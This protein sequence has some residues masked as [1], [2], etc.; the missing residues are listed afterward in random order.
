MR[1][2]VLLLLAIFLAAGVVFG[3]AVL[4]SPYLKQIEENKAPQAQAPVAEPE[5]V[6]P[7][8]RVVVLTVA[9]QPGDFI[10]AA[11]DLTIASIPA[12]EAP[13]DAF[14]S[15][16]VLSDAIA[17]NRLD[18]WEVLLAGKPG[19]PVTQSMLREVEKD[20]E[21]D[22]PE[23]QP[24][25]VDVAFLES[26]ATDPTIV[27][28]T[29][30]QLTAVRLRSDAIV[31]ISVESPL[32][33]IGDGSWVGR[34]TIVS[35][36]TLRVTSL[37]VTGH[38]AKPVFYAKLSPKEAERVRAGQAIANGRLRVEPHRDQRAIPP[39]GHVCVAQTCFEALPPDHLMQ[40]FLGART[41]SGQDTTATP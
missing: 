10:S 17:R 40:D 33:S 36:A 31:D 37:D 3:G 29:E 1:R 23:V 22:E 24:N 7:D 41:G 5:P 11:T 8:R 28:F 32:V 6:E 34:E 27:L 25:A 2:I 30:D 20:P 15:M 9:K 19:T 35:G 21:P 12:A 16:D 39:V 38:G 26:L 18:G 13:A 14:A 4:V